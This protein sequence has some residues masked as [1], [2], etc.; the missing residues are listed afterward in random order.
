MARARS[1][2]FKISQIA[3]A[4]AGCVSH[5]NQYSRFA[6]FHNFRYTASVGC[7]D[8][9]ARRHSFDDDLSE[10]LSGR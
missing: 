6:V 5:G 4:I 3:S 9:L 1:G 8:W 2:S 7:H 10:R